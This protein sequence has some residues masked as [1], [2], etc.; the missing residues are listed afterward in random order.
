MHRGKNFCSRPFYSEFKTHCMN[1]L[2]INQNYHAYTK[3]IQALHYLCPSQACARPLAASRTRQWRANGQ[4]ASLES[5]RLSGEG[6]ESQVTHGP[7]PASG[8]RGPAEET[9][10]KASDKPMHAASPSDHRP[11]HGR[12]EQGT[13]KYAAAAGRQPE[14]TQKQIH[15]LNA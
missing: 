11:W 5:G 15:A 8:R 9:F 3:N 10:S 7:G 12:R 1:I 2:C 14:A 13:S 4:G 6:P